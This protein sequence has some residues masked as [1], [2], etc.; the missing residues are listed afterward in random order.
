MKHEARGDEATLLSQVT[1]QVHSAV[2][3]CRSLGGADIIISP[4]HRVIGTVYHLHLHLH[5]WSR[6][7][8]LLQDELQCGEGLR[9]HDHGVAKQR[10]GG[11]VDVLGALRVC[12]GGSQPV[13]VGHPLKRSSKDE[14]GEGA[15]WCGAACSLVACGEGGGDAG[16]MDLGLSQKQGPPYP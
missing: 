12:M 8:L 2:K 16:L 7:H 5:S 14:G 10:G 9:S 11:G 13:W 1:A 6:T 4:P 3:T 15:G